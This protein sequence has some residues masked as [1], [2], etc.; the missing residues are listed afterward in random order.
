MLLEP[1]IQ[2][3]PPAKLPQQPRLPCAGLQPLPGRDHFVSLVG[4][5]LAVCRRLGTH[6]A[7]L[8][9]DVEG[10]EDAR[11]EL[12]E[13]HKL[14][15]TVGAR[16]IGRVRSTDLVAQ[17]GEHSF[18]VVLLGCSQADVAAVQLRLHKA[19][20]GTYGIP[21]RLL[22]LMPR[23]GAAVADAQANATDLVAAA[24]AALLQPA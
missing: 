15:Q 13:Q 3:A 11:L 7:V 18:G 8:V 14:L 21:K 4:R 9:I 10:L 5:Q 19:L 20:E 24:E 2:D 16:L 1:C 23:I 6:P 17:W 12:A 22:E